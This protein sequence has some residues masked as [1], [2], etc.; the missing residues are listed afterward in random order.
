MNGTK[1]NLEH[2]AR[3]VAK[4]AHSEREPI[5]M[6]RLISGPRPFYYKL[7]SAQGIEILVF[8]DPTKPETAKLFRYNGEQIYRGVDLRKDTPA[9]TGDEV[10][11]VLQEY[12]NR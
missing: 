3:N 5:S 6:S 1:P 11:K 2:L 10:I 8:E 7:T 4:F 9:V 12:A